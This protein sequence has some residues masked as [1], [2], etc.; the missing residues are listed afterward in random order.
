V[1]CYKNINFSFK[2]SGAYEQRITYSPYYASNCSKAGV[3]IQLGGYMGG[4]ELWVGAI[5]DSQYQ[6]ETKI[7]DKQH[8]FASTFD[9]VNNKLVPFVNIVD[10]GYRINLPAWRAGRQTVLQPIFSKSDRMFTGT[11]TAVSGSI[12]SDR[13]GNERAVKY[14]KIS[15]VLKRGLQQQGSPAMMA[16]IWL[17]WTFQVNFMFERVH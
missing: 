11:E 12:A 3:H 9:R 2:P 6:D 10:K 5:T 17:A 13:S 4:E 8:Q 15:S 16:D 1:K 14:S 7:F